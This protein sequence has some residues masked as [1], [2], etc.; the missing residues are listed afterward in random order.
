[1][2]VATGDAMKSS[3]LKTSA[4]HLVQETAEL[5]NCRALGVV[6]FY[7]PNGNFQNETLAPGPQITCFQRFDLLGYH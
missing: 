3:T 2:G 1:M 5:V 4:L 7:S 6:A